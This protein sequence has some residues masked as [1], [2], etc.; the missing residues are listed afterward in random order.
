MGKSDRTRAPRPCDECGT[1]SAVLYRL[2]TD[3]D[4]A[5]WFACKACQTNAKATAQAYQY[6]GTW[7]QKKRH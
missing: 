3:V 4:G 2:R 6:G 5:W 7:K 1:L